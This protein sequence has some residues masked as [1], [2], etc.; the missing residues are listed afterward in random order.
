V[1][2]D[3]LFFD[4]IRSGD[5]GA[6]KALLD[7]DSSLLSARNQQSQG[8]VLFAIYNRQNEIRDLLLSR[9][10]V[11][12]LHEAAAAGNLVR[13]K[14]LVDRDPSLAKSYSPDGF[15]VLA[16]AAVFGHGEVAQ[17]LHTMGGD[18]NAVATNGSGYTALTGS[19]ASGHTQIVKWLLE[20]GVS[21]NYSYA[22]GYTPL[23]TAA[24]NGHLEILKA[25]LKHG[26]DLHAKTTDGKNA[27]AYA[28]ERKHTSVVEFL[29]AQ[30]LT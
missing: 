21:P 11:L 27:L 24:A 14:E 13:A 20:S 12:E 4:A 17:Y 19:V 29:R 5:S 25:L 26:A 7:Q 9:G 23:L 15:P 6:V 30:G 10:A 16:L 2:E 28:E 1:S 3:Q 22:N 18:L 8:P